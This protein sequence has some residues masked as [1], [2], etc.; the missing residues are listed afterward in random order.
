MSRHDAMLQNLVGLL[1]EQIQVTVQSEAKEGHAVAVLIEEDVGMGRVLPAVPV[2]NL[3]H[4]EATAPT[5]VR[6]SDRSG[7]K[8][9]GHLDEEADDK[10]FHART[11]VAHEL[12]VAENRFLT[13][14]QLG[15]KE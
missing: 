6:D 9:F 8:I 10:A 1:A 5:L 14:A 12:R 3:W 11:I 2:L 13:G 4:R 15:I 7:G